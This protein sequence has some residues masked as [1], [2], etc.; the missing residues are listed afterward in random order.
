MAHGKRILIIDDDLTIV[1]ILKDLLQD[2]GYKVETASSMNVMEK[3][4]S[5]LPDLILLDMMMPGVSGVEVSQML[6]S[7]AR[8]NYIPIV[9]ISAAA[10]VEDMARRA[11]TDA[12][13][14]KPFDMP[15]V[16]HTIERLIG[17]S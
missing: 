15:Q 3:T 6:R 7:E 9:A 10:T 12:V 8:T 4:L 5:S 1:M 11:D 13:L 14:K 16:L 2:A 17:D